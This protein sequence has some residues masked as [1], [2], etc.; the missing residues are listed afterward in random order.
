MSLCCAAQRPADHRVK[1]VGIEYIE[2]AGD[3]KATEEWMGTEAL[4]LRWVEGPP[5]IKAVG[6]KTES[7]TIVMR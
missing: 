7:G 4:P 5:G 3:R 1:P 2:L 6:I